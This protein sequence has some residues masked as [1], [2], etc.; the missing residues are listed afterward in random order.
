[1]N[2]HV[3]VVVIVV[4]IVDVVIAVAFCK[5]DWFYKIG[6]RQTIK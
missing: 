4:V 5:F 1:M 6:V 2:A 3:F